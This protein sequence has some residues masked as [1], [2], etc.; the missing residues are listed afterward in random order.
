MARYSDLSEEQKRELIFTPEERAQLDEAKK[1]PI[2]YDADCPAVTPEK[3]VKFKRVH[4][5]KMLCDIR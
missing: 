3:A 1:R 2:V 5:R 4:A